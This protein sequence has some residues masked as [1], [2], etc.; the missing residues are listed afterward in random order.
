MRKGRETAVTAAPSRQPSVRPSGRPSLERAGQLAD[1]IMD[2][3]TRLFIE[4]GFGATSVE[5]IA[6]A[7]GISK[8][9]YYTR[10]AG[11][12]EVFEAAVLR[13]VA[14]NLRTG[15]PAQAD[16]EPLEERLVRMAC[17]LLEWILRPEVLGLYRVTIAEAPRFPE[18]ARTVVDF[19][20]LGAARSFEP[21]FRTWA[22]GNPSDDEI[23]FVASQFLQS[24]AAEPFHRAVQGLDAAG[25]DAP[26]REKVRRAVRLFLRGF[27]QRGEG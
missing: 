25:L 9:T 24:V 16:S 17:E 4:H 12:A 2:H 7:A 6:A 13:Y 22:A 26:R 18:L 21:V 11:K 3:A 1:T 15:E 19:A 20:I 10:F 27:S 23:A 8:K 5:A 14:Q